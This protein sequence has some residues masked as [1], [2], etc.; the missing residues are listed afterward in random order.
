M[1]KFD[2]LVAD[3]IKDSWGKC[4]GASSDAVSNLTKH[5]N[6]YLPRDYLDFLRF[7]NGSATAISA[8]PL[9]CILYP[10][11]E[12]LE[13]NEDYEI[14]EHLP[15]YFLIGTSGGGDSILFDT[16]TT[17]WRVCTVAI[18]FEEEG[19]SEVAPNFMELLKMF[20]SPEE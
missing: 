5:C 6:Y 3:G 11:E 12:V 10:A 2:F 14:S 19:V 20:G 15:G 8:E 16:R 9:W 7:S 4:A 13:L 1:H 18:P 17:P